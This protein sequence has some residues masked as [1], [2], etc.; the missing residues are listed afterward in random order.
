MGEADAGQALPELLL[1]GKHTFRSGSQDIGQAVRLRCSAVLLAVLR[2]AVLAL[3]GLGDRNAWRA[4][5][6]GEHRWACGEAAWPGD[7]RWEGGGS[8]ARNMV[9]PFVFKLLQVK[10]N[11]F[12][13]LSPSKRAEEKL[14]GRG[15]KLRITRQ[16]RGYRSMSEQPG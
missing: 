11:D 5:R 3:A 8:P 10:L 6:F 7:G 15:I 9:D 1:D 13:S 2:C 12:L 14:E 16:R 4:S